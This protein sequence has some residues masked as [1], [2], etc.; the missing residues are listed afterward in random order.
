MYSKE[1]TLTVLERPCTL[2]KKG[3]VFAQLLVIGSQSPH[4]PEKPPQNQTIGL[5][6]KVMFSEIQTRS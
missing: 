5:Y 4:F 1:Q 6:K 2:N 3:F